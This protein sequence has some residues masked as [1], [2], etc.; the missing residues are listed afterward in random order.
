MTL[1]AVALL[2]LAGFAPAL[3]L[4]QTG[5]PD[6]APAPDRPLPAP[7]TTLEPKTG[8]GV[9]YLCGGVGEEESDAMKQAAS[10]YDLMVT[11]AT[12]TGAYLADV[13]VVIADAR[14]RP[15]LRTGCDAP[16]MLVEFEKPGNYRVRADANGHTVTRNARV[17]SG[18]KVRTVAMAWP[19]Q[20]VD[21]GRTPALQGEQS[22]G[23]SGPAR[24][25]VA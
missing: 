8:N 7:M 21:M 25:R 16:I 18:G 20:L 19:V 2:F 17:R 4:A 13:S 12:S 6:R 14:G 10:D 24:I 23:G 5:A 3:S 9:T 22:S 15:L 1:K 11:F